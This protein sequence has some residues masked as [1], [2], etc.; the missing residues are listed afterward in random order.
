[1]KNK[2]N[3]LMYSGKQFFKF[4][5]NFPELLCI[6]EQKGINDNLCLFA[7]LY[8]QF[9]HE[10]TDIFRIFLTIGSD[11]RGQHVF[12][13]GQIDIED[14]SKG[15]PEGHLGMWRVIIIVDGGLIIE[16]VVG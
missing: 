5:I 6:R 1:M 13:S 11:F 3:S 8:V 15:T 4:L 10:Y 12:H 14:I 9:L 2:N 16:P 7:C